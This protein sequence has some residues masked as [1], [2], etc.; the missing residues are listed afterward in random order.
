MGEASTPD[1]LAPR[2]PRGDRARPNDGAPRPTSLRTPIVAAVIAANVLTFL[3]LLM[4]VNSVGRRDRATLARE[5]TLQLGDHLE[6]AFDNS[7]RIRP[8]ALLDWRGWRWFDDAIVA[9]VPSQDPKGRF[10]VAGIYLNPLGMAKRRVDFDQQQALKMMREAVDQESAIEGNGQFA[11]PI[12]TGLNRDEPWGAVWFQKRRVAVG[13]PPIAKLLPFFGLT[14]LAVTAGILMLLR[15]RVLEPIEQLASVARRIEAGDLAARV[16]LST[17]GNDEMALLASG[18]NDMAARTEHYNHELEEAVREATEKVRS[19]EAAAMTQ[20]RLASTGELAAGIA[21]ELNNPLGGLMNAVESLRR[22]DIPDHRRVEYLELVRG[23]LERMGE[24]VGRL[25]RLSPREASVSDVRLGR[26]LTDALGL[27]RHRALECGIEVTV[28]ASAQGGVAMP[29]FEPGTREFLDGLPVVRGAANELGQAFLNLLVNA[30]DAIVDAR[31]S[32]A[33]TGGSGRVSI[34]IFEASGVSDGAATGPRICLRFEDDGPGIADEVIDR[35]VNPFFT[36]K[37]Q[38]KGTG[39]GLAIV[40]NIVAAHGGVVLLEGRPGLGLR[41]T[42]E[43]PL[44]PE[45]SDSSGGA[46]S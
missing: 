32:G 27:V 7:G 21:H 33:P 17:A 20:R 23:G 44:P 29:A 45:S 18:F 12:G 28:S 3:V 22:S 39:L 34:S 2:P 35:V 38:G 10:S 13:E 42:I 30:I 41:S 9:Q 40:H 14:L 1:S 11:V 5:Y 36:T 25:L 31:E 15:R 24:T 43:L 46:L 8:A 4:I 26:P 37:E 16:H 19:A 6:D